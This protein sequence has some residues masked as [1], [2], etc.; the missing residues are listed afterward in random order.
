M[1][2]P[3]HKKKQKLVKPSH[4]KNQKLVKPKSIAKKPVALESTLE[5]LVDSSEMAMSRQKSLGKQSSDKLVKPCHKKGNKL[6]K[7]SP[8]KRNKL[9]K[10]KSYAKKTDG[11]KKTLNEVMKGW[12]KKKP[13]KKIEP[14]GNKCTRTKGQK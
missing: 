3:S 4:K 12:F 9:V 14:T 6:V 10:P 8:K 13:R 7:P 2:K 11:L 5:E 1:V